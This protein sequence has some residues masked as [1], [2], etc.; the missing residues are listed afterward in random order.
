MTARSSVRTM[1]THPVPLSAAD[2]G[3]TVTL[4]VASAAAV[5]GALLLIYGLTRG[6]SGGEHR[7]TG[8]ARGHARHKRS[9]RPDHSKEQNGPGRKRTRSDPY[10]APMERWIRGEDEDDKKKRT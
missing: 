1:T 6:E 7:G 9:H 2:A 10:T 3:T 4:I 8:R 5:A